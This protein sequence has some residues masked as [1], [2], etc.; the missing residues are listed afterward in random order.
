ME[1]SFWHQ[2]PAFV[3]AAGIGA[4]LFVGI[5]QQCSKMRE[6]AENEVSN[7]PAQ[8]PAPGNIGPKPNTTTNKPSEALAGGDSASFA[9]QAAALS[10]MEEEEM[11]Q[12]LD[13]LLQAWLGV[14]R[15]GALAWLDTLPAGS[16][17]DAAAASL[18]EIWGA[19]DPKAA[20]AWLSQRLDDKHY[21][22]A[23]GALCSV[24][25]EQ[26]PLQAA[27]WAQRLL[28][29]RNQA[30]GA[31]VVGQIW[32]ETNPQDAAKHL[33]T[34]PAEQQPALA[35]GIATGW[36]SVNPAAAA[37]W[38]EEVYLRNPNIPTSA[39][40]MIVNHWVAQD[41]GAASK[42]LNALPEGPLYDAAAEIFAQ[43]SAEISPKDALLWS[44]NLSR[45]DARA[46]AV[47]HTVE[48]WYAQD[49]QGLLATLPETMA[50]LAPDLQKIVYEV[51][52]SKDPQFKTPE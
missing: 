32:A 11:V 45:P 21:Q 34:L 29:P 4:L 36:G 39:A 22:G 19:Q 30:K 44:K 26:N 27:Q 46:D 20:A 18:M 7:G 51:I 8:S 25:A 52:S 37:K 9:V 10:G 5:P 33:E 28:S 41:A 17:R 13:G 42:W 15:A 12:Q 6:S 31:L 35:Q 2:I 38:L 3:L 1:S 16:F 43:S 50:S 47:R 24:W 14:D 23:L 49:S 48:Q 40:G